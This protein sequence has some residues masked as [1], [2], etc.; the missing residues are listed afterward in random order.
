M[1]NA[2]IPMNEA[3]KMTRMMMQKNYQNQN[4]IKAQQIL[5]TA[6]EENL[7]VKPV[8]NK[9]FEGIAK[10]VPEDLVVRAMDKTRYRYSIAY[11]HAQKITQNTKQMH[12][13]A[14]AI[15]AGYTAGIRN[16]DTIQVMNR[17]QSRTQQRTITNT[18]V[19]AEESFLSLRDM[20]RLGVSSQ[21]AREV[22]CHA[23]NQ[24]YSAQEMKQLRHSFMNQSTSNNP[25]KL[26]NQYSYAISH[27]V[28]AGNLSSDQIGKNAQTGKG[29]NQ[30]S[31]NGGSGSGSAGGSGGGPGGGSGGGPGGGS[32]GGSG[33][34]GSK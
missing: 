8:M 18:E 2:G 14:K 31:S 25:I 33:G 22:V 1:I 7:P 28:K 5:I 9:A 34:G 16:A 19:L 4:T 11:K 3:V 15:A 17:L 26:A 21:S 24:R 27:G 6:A 12:N 23:L 29:G 32:G 10:N 13:I 30:G 20:A